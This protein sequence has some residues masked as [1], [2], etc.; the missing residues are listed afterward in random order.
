MIDLFIFDLGGVLV[1]EF[2]VIPEAARRLG[3]AE[4]RMRD[5]AH[6]D[7]EAYMSGRIG[8]GEFWDRFRARSGLGVPE[9][10]W[11][12][13]F[14]P[15]LDETVEALA[16]SLKA[17][18]RVVC[19]TNTIDAH[20]DRLLER[21][22][23]RCFDAVYASHILGVSKPRREFW[24]RILEAEGRDAD[25]AFFTDDMEEN[26]LA[27]RDLGIRSHLFEGA[28][29]LEAAL[30]AAGVPVPAGEARP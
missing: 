24:I 10:Y 20:Y 26:V 11:A 3:L 4:D 15:V 13:L 7:M 29:G 25:G 18:G 22:F 14:R 19:G 21:G 5:L 23:Y 28:P 17:V 1:S 12:T 16:L 9:N 6:P 8:S 30:E 27:A 2:D